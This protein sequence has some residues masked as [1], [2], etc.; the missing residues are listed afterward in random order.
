MKFNFFILLPFIFSIAIWVLLLWPLGLWGAIIS[1][2]TTG[3]IISIISYCQ[4]K[5]RGKKKNKRY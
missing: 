4:F 5:K 2:L 1:V 3:V